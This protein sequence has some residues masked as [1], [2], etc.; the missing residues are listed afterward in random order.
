MKRIV[1]GTDGSA[2][3]QKAVLEAADLAAATRADVHIVTAYKSPPSIQA[4]T[5]SAAAAG[6][7]PMDSYG[8][9]D[10][11][12]KDAEAMLAAAAELVAARGV[13]VEFHGA[14]GDPADVVLRTAESQ[15]R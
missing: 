11:L 7:A 1:V 5:A 9:S 2:A 3:A 8:L 6:V 14:G 10:S 15:R 4:M 13:P 12:A